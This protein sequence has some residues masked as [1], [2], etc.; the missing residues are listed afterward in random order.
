M[1]IMNYEKRLICPVCYGN[2]KLG[3]YIF[4]QN[5]AC[6]A[7]YNIIDGLPVMIPGN[8]D[9]IK[10]EILSLK[11]AEH[12][13]DRKILGIHKYKIDYFIKKLLYECFHIKL[14]K[15]EDQRQYWL[16]R[17]NV[18]CEEFYNTKYEK[19]ELF[20]QNLLV[21]R[22]KALDFNSVFEAGC[23]FG[24]NIKRLKHE[25]PDKEVGG[26]DFS[27]TQLLNGRDKYLKNNSITLFEGDICRLPLKNDCYDVGFSVGVFMNINLKKIDAAIDNMV[28]VCRKY[29]IH[30]EYDENNATEQL[31]E[32]R[33]FKTNIITHDYRRLYESRGLKVRNFFTHH[34]FK[35][36]YDDFMRDKKQGLENLWEDWEGES[37]YILILLEK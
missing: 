9:L 6:N 33:A 11:N 17:G 27:H 28:R 31:R 12:M 22:V 32:R 10:E 13:F 8:T 36:K 1:D 21:D 26:V 34:D 3:E 19:L 2:I 4:C 20:Y 37:K 16:N 18:Y 14:P 25:Y 5:K 15:L 30:L 23:G 24:W 29:I 35:D 7:K